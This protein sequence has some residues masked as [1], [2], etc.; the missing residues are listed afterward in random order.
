MNIGNRA[1]ELAEARAEAERD[2]S[3][4]RVQAAAR[5]QAVRPEGGTPEGGIFVCDCGEP[6]SDARRAAVPNARLCFDCATF[7]ER[8]RRA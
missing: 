1:I 3:I 8:R 4:R 2:A 6:I 5:G 7:F